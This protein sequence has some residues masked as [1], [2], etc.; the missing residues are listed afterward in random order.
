MK[1]LGKLKLNSE[2]M[3]SHNE[4]VSFRGGSGTCG[5]KKSNGEIICGLSMAEAEGW[6]NHFG[7]GNY[8]CCDSCASNGGSASY[9]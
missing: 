4:L 9:C 3:L 8:W 2:K 1:K 5:L 7:A 6:A